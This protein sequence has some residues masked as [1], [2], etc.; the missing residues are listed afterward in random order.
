MLLVDLKSAT[1]WQCHDHTL[2]PR[3]CMPAASAHAH[4]IIWACGAQ[5][6]STTYIDSSYAKQN[7]TMLPHQNTHL[8]GETWPQAQLCFPSCAGEAQLCL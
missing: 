7:A 1:G 3:S 2:N 5:L 8:Q 4:L 6:P